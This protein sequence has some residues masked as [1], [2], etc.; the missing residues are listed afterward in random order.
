MIEFGKKVGIDRIG[1]IS[2]FRE[3]MIKKNCGD[4]LGM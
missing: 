1:R 3:K 2:P 4:E